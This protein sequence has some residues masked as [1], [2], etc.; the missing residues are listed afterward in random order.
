VL[1]RATDR[2]AR[3]NRDEV[4]GPLMPLVEWIARSWNHIAGP[5]STVGSRPVSYSWMRTHCLR[6]VGEG[7]A[8]PH[9]CFHPYGDD[10]IKLVWSA[11]DE[12]QPYERIA[13]TTSGSLV[14]S[15]AVVLDELDRLVQSV[16]ARLREM[17]PSDW[18]TIRLDKA[19][20][21][22]RNRQHVDHAA[23]RLGARAGLLWADLVDD[24]RVTLREVAAGTLD[25]VTGELLVFYDDRRLEEVLVE[26]Q[27][28]WETCR[29]SG[30]ASA[31]WKR[32]RK[33]LA[34]HGT[35]PVPFLP[36]ER[37]WQFAHVVRNTL[38]WPHDKASLDDLDEHLDVSFVTP[39]WEAA[40][41]DSLIAWDAGHAPIRARAQG[42]FRS[43]RE[44]FLIARDLYPVLFEGD[45]GQGH[46]R[47]LFEGSSGANPVANAFAAELLAPVALLGRRVAGRTTISGD[48]LEEIAEEIGA[49][50]GCVRHQIENHGLAKIERGWL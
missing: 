41:G 33:A 12:E 2:V 15:K 18:R 11:D 10:H 45:T 46:A 44:R 14:L 47:V 9:A 17:A 7:T 36:W 3:L 13:F 42:S 1:T 21:L 37:G 26:G 22:S 39:T 29:S 24:T 30:R 31:D 43:A 48:A 40:P 23:E 8:L 20:D 35:G 4:Y 34:E 5:R 25:P 6:F 16:L 19:W 49:T 32:I 27:A 50:V 28:L 38:G